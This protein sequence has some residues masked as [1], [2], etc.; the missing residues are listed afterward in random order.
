MGTNS[1]KLGENTP[2]SISTWCGSSKTR[3]VAIV[4]S[5]EAEARSAYDKINTILKAGLEDQLGVNSSTNV[6]QYVITIKSES[7]NE[8]V[9]LVKTSLDNNG[10]G[11]PD[12]YIHRIVVSAQPCTTITCKFGNS[13][14]TYIPVGEVVGDIYAIVNANKSNLPSSLD[15][16]Q[17]NASAFYV[18]LLDSTFASGENVYFF[19]ESL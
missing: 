8:T 1:S 18:G 3:G 17:N 14:P 9:T 15:E 12:A 5:S 10:D 16:F 11:N 13:A 2:K 7:R 19:Y 6:L 4:A